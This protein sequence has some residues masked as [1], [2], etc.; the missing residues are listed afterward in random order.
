MR[1]ITLIV[2]ALIL[3]IIGLIKR[4]TVPLFLTIAVVFLLVLYAV[5]KIIIEQ[6]QSKDEAKSK[7]YGVLKPKSK[8]LLSSKKNTYPK[9]EFGDSG[10]ILVFA[11]KPDEPLFQIFRD[12]SLTIKIKRGKIKVSTI[13]RDRGG[14]IIAELMNSEWKVN[15][16]NSFDRNY[17]KNALEV[18]DS[19]GDVV[20]QLILVEDRVQFQGKF[21]DSRGNGVAFGKVRGP[22]GKIGG[23]I[24]ITG[25]AHPNLTLHI[26]PIFKYPSELHLGELRN[27]H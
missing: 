12:N 26:E 25:T 6:K 20:L 19:N 8:I 24:E 2:L 11:G 10:A 23:S 13:I 22:N 3:A 4:E 5:I 27:E 21:Y 17:S 14:A 9:F 1:K 18:K 7:Y 15:P 16:N